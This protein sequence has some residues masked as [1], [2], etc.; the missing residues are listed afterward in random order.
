MAITN[1]YVTL[2]DLK[3]YL[4][5]S[6]ATEDARLE[7]AIESASRAIDAYTRRVFYATSA[8]KYFQ[9]EPDFGH[10]VIIDDDLL[11]VTEIATDDQNT[12]VYTAWAG[13]DYELEPVNSGPPYNM[14]RVAPLAVK[15]FPIW[16]RGV[17][18]TGTW[19][20]AATAPQAV[21]D[22]C[23]IL[24]ARYYKRKDAPFG[25][26][27]TPELGLMRVTSKDHDVAALLMPYRRMDVVGV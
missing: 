16:P 20:F 21:G 19:G 24:G 14:I 13:S 3:T 11:T 5:I 6:G 4:N 26:V 25:V 10:T 7:T 17:R 18:I 1:G 2:A 23:L 9:S 15:T 27:G 12:R 8:V 22:A